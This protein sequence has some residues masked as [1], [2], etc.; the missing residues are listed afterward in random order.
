MPSIIHQKI[1]FLYE[2]KVVTILIEIE[3][4]VAA[5]KL[6]PKEISI[7]PSFKVCMLYED[8]LDEQIMS[9][10]HSINFMLRLGQG[11]NQNGPPEFI[12]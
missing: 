7:S 3:A 9:M 5:L 10:M 8:E 12:K 4:T 11:K 6:T 2:G 1:K